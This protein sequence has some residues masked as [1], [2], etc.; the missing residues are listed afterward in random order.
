MA[1]DFGALTDHFSI[2]T[3]DL[4]LV[5]SS[6]T[7]VAE[8]RAE[9][10]DENGDIA[11]VTYYGNDGGTI[12][13]ASCTYLLKSGTL[14]LDSLQVGEL[15]TGV[16]VESIEIATSNGDW[17]RVTVSGKLGTFA[18]QAPTGSAA[19]ATLPADIDLVGAKKAQV[20]G[21]TVGSGCK[22]TGCSMSVAASITQADDGLGEPVAYAVSFDIATVTA[23]FVRITAQPSWTVTGDLIETQ[24]PS[25]VEPQAAYHTSTA[26]GEIP[27]TRDAA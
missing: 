7:P 8:S 18:V 23:E 16:I 12:S 10:R 14:G 22:L 20:M 21:F 9:A 6:K 13:D 1:S 17:P 11:A 4:I 27:I 24:A 2:A 3:A 19:T 15:S 25:T 5:E 26:T